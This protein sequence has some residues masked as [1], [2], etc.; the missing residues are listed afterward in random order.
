MPATEAAAAVPTITAFAEASIARYP[1]RRRFRRRCS[2]RAIHLP[3]SNMRTHWCI[4]V[5]SRMSSRDERVG[6]SEM[7]RGERPVR[8]RVMDGDAGCECERG[9]P[10]G[11]ARLAGRRK[12]CWSERRRVRGRPIGGLPRRCT[13][14]DRL[15]CRSAVFFAEIE[16]KCSYIRWRGRDSRCPF[17]HGANNAIGSMLPCR[18]T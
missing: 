13:T 15:V 17:S 9:E 11:Q 8:E 14:L 12:R 3:Y 10:E 2:R 16:R 7:E 18:A 4:G 6:A 1:C 5:L